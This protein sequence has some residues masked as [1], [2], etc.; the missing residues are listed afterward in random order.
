MAASHD[1]FLMRL[2]RELIRLA[3]QHVRPHIP[4]RLG[5]LKR[6]I[7]R[8]V[9]RAGLARLHTPEEWAKIV[10]DGRGPINQRGKKRAMVWYKN[11]RRDPRLRGGKSPTKGRPRRLTAAEFRRDRKANLLIVARR[12]GPQKP[13]RFFEH[14]P[15]DGMAGFPRKAEKVTAERF[16]TH[17]EK[18]MGKDLNVKETIEF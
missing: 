11:P 13:Q 15:G 5:H 8:E 18:F 6:S 9:I 14:G 12:V 16:G 7:K 17:V 4:V 1:A 10:H 3:E 2:T